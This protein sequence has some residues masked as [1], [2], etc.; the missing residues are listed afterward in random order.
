M[1]KAVCMYL[2]VPIACPKLMVIVIHGLAVNEYE[3]GAKGG[4]HVDALVTHDNTLCLLACST[5]GDTFSKAVVT[6][7]STSRIHFS[8]SMR[9]VGYTEPISADGGLSL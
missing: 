9:T 3:D 5:T 6:W 7:Y 8:W 4:S 2:M 1:E